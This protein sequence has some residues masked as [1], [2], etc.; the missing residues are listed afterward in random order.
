[1]LR[2]FFSPPLASVTIPLLAGPFRPRRLA[3]DQGGHRPVVSFGV[4]YGARTA[5]WRDSADRVFDGWDWQDAPPVS[6]N[7][8]PR[9]RTP[10]TGQPLSAL[11]TARNRHGEGYFRRGCRNPPTRL[12]FSRFK[13]IVHQG[14]FGTAAIESHCAN[15]DPVEVIAPRR[16]AVRLAAWAPRAA[17]PGRHAAQARTP[18]KQGRIHETRASR[19]GESGTLTDPKE[20][21]NARWP[22]QVSRR[23]ET[24]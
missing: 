19:F 6:P 17:Q 7:V 20:V 14:P 16:M 9:R 8:Q 10:R 12:I 2:H 13:Q 1:M 11:P 23:K 5:S 15:P 21:R 24:R 22:S 3:N 18:G 4:A